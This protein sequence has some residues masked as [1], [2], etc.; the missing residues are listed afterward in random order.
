MIALIMCSAGKRVGPKKPD[1]QNSIHKRTSS[2][3]K[4]AI[5]VEFASLMIRSPMPTC[6]DLLCVYFTPAEVKLVGMLRSEAYYE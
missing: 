3:Q 5:V 1:L 6:V 2:Y 4:E